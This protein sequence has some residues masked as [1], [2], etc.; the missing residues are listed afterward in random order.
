LTDSYLLKSDNFRV[1]NPENRKEYTDIWES[2]EQDL[3]K[4]KLDQIIG[5]IRTMKL[6][7]KDEESVYE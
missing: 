5:F 3:G 7:N 1:M 2:D 6:K 4:E